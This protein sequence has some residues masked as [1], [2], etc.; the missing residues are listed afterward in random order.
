MRSG[1]KKEPVLNSDQKIPLQSGFI[2]KKINSCFFY[3]FTLTTATVNFNYDKFQY[4]TDLNNLLFENCSNILAI[5]I[6]SN[7]VCERNTHK[8]NY[9]DVCRFE[10]SCHVM[11][12]VPVISLKN[13][14]GWYSDAVKRQHFRNEIAVH[15][16]LLHA[17]I[18]MHIIIIIFYLSCA[19][20]SYSCFFCAFR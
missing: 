9:C 8:S 7:D 13:S 3:R 17:S 1:W 20:V 15:E 16:N 5:L 12:F 4:L 6:H 2:S 11:S 10:L 18:T 14:A 19:H